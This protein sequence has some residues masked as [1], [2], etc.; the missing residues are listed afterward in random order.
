MIATEFP[1]SLLALQPGP[2]ALC[3]LGLL[4][5]Y[6][7]AHVLYTAF[8]SPLS[9]IPGPKLCALTSVVDHY[10]SM[11]GGRRAEWIHSLHREYGT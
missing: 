3:G 8:L 6:K 9:K 10:Q 1:R 4:V 7:L 11:V 2:L 5:A